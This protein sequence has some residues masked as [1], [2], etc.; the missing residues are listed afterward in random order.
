MT[1][2]IGTYGIALLAGIL[3]A[4][5]PCVL[6]LVPVLMGSAVTAHRFGP[7]ALAAGV[8]LSYTIAGVFLASVGASLGL[9][10]ETFRQTAAVLLV[11]FGLILLSA[12]L[13]AL[14]V[15]ATAG[16]TGSGQG[17][18]SRLTLDG[19]G[20]QFAL[21]LLRGVVWSPCVG[22]MLG[23][24]TTLASQ[25]RDLAQISLLMAVFGIGASVPML[26]IGSLS[27]ATMLPAR[28][29]VARS[30]AGMA[31][32]PDYALLKVRLLTSLARAPRGNFPLFKPEYNLAPPRLIDPRPFGN[33]PEGAAAA[34]AQPLCIQLADVDT[35]RRH[36]GI[37]RRRVRIG[38]RGL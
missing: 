16:L 32:S 33:F 13:Q 15:R 30:F 7:W 1:F 14:F 2:G 12:R 21:G 36:C 29:L 37:R 34:D 25:G 22:P 9:D 4:L 24:A 26:L 35:G 38:H 31:D 18:L 23:A 20:G 8:A 17:L 11:L 19:V 28:G 10:G 6:P 27:R 3:T 5:S